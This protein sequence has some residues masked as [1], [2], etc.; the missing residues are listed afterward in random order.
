M[1]MP[2]CL[3]DNHSSRNS[4]GC[5]TIAVRAVAAKPA[6]FAVP[7]RSDCFQ[8]MIQAALVITS[9]LVCS[10]LLMTCSTHLLR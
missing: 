2:S 4:K 1:G 3:Q 6:L 10:L 9:L 7:L 8:P 5:Q